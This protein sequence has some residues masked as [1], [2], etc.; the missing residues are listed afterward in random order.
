MKPEEL[1][2]FKVELEQLG[3]EEVNL[4]VTNRSFGPRRL[5][6]VSNG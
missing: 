4:K 5:P 2:K 3:E 1:Q 6:Y